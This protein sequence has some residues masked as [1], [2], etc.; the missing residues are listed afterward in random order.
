MPVK[1]VERRLAAILA[2]DVAG[3][4]RMMEV[5]EAGTLARLK[6]HLGEVVRPKI[7]A[8]RGNIVKTTGDGLLAEFASVVSAVECAVEIQR[9]M[10]ERN[11]GEAEDSLIRFRIGIN[12]GDII[13]DDGDIFGDGVNVA[14]RLEGLADPG[15]ICVHRDVRGQVQNRLP[16]TFDDMGEVEVKNIARPLRVYRIRLDGTK[17]PKPAAKKKAR[18]LLWRRAALPLAIVAVLAI[19][20]GASYWAGWNPFRDTAQ[21]EAAKPLVPD[22]RSIAVLPFANISNDPE[23][24]YFADGL[25]E[26]LTTQLSSISQLFVI[27]RGS[28][29]G[30]RGKT[31]QP[32]DVAHDFGVRYVLEGSVRKAG[33][34]LRISADLVEAESGQ[35]L[36]AEQYDREI[37]DIFALQDDVIAQIVSALAVE[38]TDLEQQH[39]ARVPTSNLQAYDYYLRAEAEGYYN[40]DAETFVR[41]LALYTKAIKIDPNF[42]D[43]HAGYA[44]LAAEVWRLDSWDTVMPAAMA[45]KQAYDEASRALEIDPNNARAYTVLAI[46]QLTD[47]RYEDAIQSARRAISLNPNDAE[48]RAN[49]GIVLAYSGQHEDA[50]T[51]IEQAVQLNP[52]APPGFRLLAGIVFYLVGDNDRAAKEL[53][54]VKAVWPAA[55]TMREYLAATYAA[56]GQLDM[57]RGEIAAFPHLSFV[58]LA[59]YRLAYES[60]M[61]E[62]DL[63]RHMELLKAAGMPDWPFGFQGHPEDRVT[64]TDLKNLVTARTWSGNSPVRDEKNAPFMLQIDHENRVAYRS[65]NTFLTGEVRIDGEEVC[66]RFDGYRRSAWL[67][68]NIYRSKGASPT[69]GNEEYVYVFPDGLRYFSL[70]E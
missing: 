69:A 6:A 37:A 28:M 65:T 59:S 25:T 17:A 70:Q 62:E 34:R 24:Q 32:R 44:R 10:A 14:A 11:T 4:S 54:A 68:G 15:G 61:R 60:Y 52:A 50:V 51:A 56:R 12:V 9:S 26:D 21:P 46:L 45:R 43:A 5:D 33:T 35:Q 38:L 67:C 47:G 19:A 23:Q 36:W 48:A 7:A 55:Q 42:A 22:K 31:V 49:L 8:H 2:A 1:D 63:T 41:T 3:Y 16:L 53:E 18:A 66:M 29:Q 57:A 20:G 27:S 64:G 30:Y 39:I 40:N 13:I 58:N